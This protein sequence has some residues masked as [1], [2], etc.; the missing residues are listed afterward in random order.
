[1]YYAGISSSF[2]IKTMGAHLKLLHSHGTETYN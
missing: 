2:N 1:M